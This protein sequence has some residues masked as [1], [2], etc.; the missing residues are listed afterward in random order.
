MHGLFDDDYGGDD[1]ES[2][3]CPDLKVLYSSTKRGHRLPVGGL[4]K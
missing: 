4:C 3:E 1:P 2:T